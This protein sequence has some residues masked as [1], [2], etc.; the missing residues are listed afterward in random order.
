SY[1]QAFLYHYIYEKEN[2]IMASEVEELYEKK[3]QNDK[4]KIIENML[5]L[6]SISVE[7]IARMTSTSVDYVQ[8][9]AGGMTTITSADILTKCPVCG[10]DIQADETV[11]STCGTP[12]VQYTKTAANTTAPSQAGSAVNPA[13]G[14]QAVQSAQSGIPISSPQA[15][16]PMQTGTT[17]QAASEE[18]V[19]VFS[20]DTDSY[21]S[22]SYRYQPDNGV[23]TS[24]NWRS[25]DE[26]K[27]TNQS[28][29]YRSTANV[30]AIKN[31]NDSS[32]YGYDGLEY[33]F[34]VKAVVGMVLAIHGLIFGFIGWIPLAGAGY[35]ILSYILAIVALALAGSAG[36]WAHLRNEGHCTAAK[37]L[38]VITLIVATI[39]LI[40]TVASCNDLTSSYSSYY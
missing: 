36:S 23:K 35:M 22:R 13:S 33:R 18:P 26:K 29:T 34:S 19:K 10:A 38:G 8:E 6:G 11:C 39:G 24:F 27:E 28:I 21:S 9:V 25:D 31:K 14:T 17:T 15:V 20:D 3:M 7:E 32:R 1:I 16:Q 30:K 37:V 4:K 12:R 2:E 5:E 40:I